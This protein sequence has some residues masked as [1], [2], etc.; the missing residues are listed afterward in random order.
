MA[1]SDA[2]GK[3]RGVKLHPLLANPHL[4]EG[5]NCLKSV[6]V[7]QLDYAGDVWKCNKKK[8]FA[9]GATQVWTKRRLLWRA[10]R[11]RNAAVVPALVGIQPH[12]IRR[13]A[14]KL[15]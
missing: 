9:L 14:R 7:S 6:M 8:E 11:T 13:D 5:I 1:K 12:R 2:N 4:D 15:E 10:K 3:V